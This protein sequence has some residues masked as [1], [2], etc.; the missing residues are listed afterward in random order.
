MHSINGHNL[1]LRFSGNFFRLRRGE[2]LSIV[3][4]VIIISARSNLLVTAIQHATQHT[5]SG[6][7]IQELVY[8]GVASFAG[9]H[10]Q[11]RAVSSADQDVGVREYP[12]RRSI[13]DYIVKHSTDVGK[14]SRVGWPTQQLSYVVT[15]AA[16]WQKIKSRRINPDNR[17]F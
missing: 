17:I 7:L 8:Y 14:E 10:D 4:A 6:E 15:G 9:P 11:Q 2:R 12:E 16:T 13:D 1:L 3:I 5:L